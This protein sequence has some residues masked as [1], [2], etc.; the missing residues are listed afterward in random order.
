MTIAS[1]GIPWP[2]YKKLSVGLT[3]KHF[4]RLYINAQSI[5]DYLQAYMAFEKGQN[6]T[7]TLPTSG[8]YWSGMNFNTR[9]PDFVYLGTGNG[10]D[11]G[12]MYRY[13]HGI[14]L[15]LQVSDVYTRIRWWD[16]KQSS[17]IPIDAR[18][19]ISW[20]PDFSIWGLFEDPL[21][22]FDIDDLF[23][24]QNH[25]VFMKLHAGGEFKMLFKILQV[26]AGMNQGYF[27]YGAGLDLSLYFL[28]KIP[29]LKWLRPDSVYF[30]QFNPNRKDFLERN[31]CC[32]LFT[33]LFSELLY[34]HLKIDFLSYSRE[35][36]DYA[37]AVEDKQ[38]SVRVS[39]SY[40]Y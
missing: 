39:L 38:S 33:S 35:L 17:F 25:N 34:A 12:F 23:F 10:F 8:Q 26:R 19:G 6:L 3:F 37:G 13:K 32:C 4:H 36:G 28:S 20:R 2:T 11:V 9:L 29:V 1:V 31:P 14:N 5:D 24:R 15:G 40:S 18:A 27:T 22:A 21:V 30:P 16:G 7:D